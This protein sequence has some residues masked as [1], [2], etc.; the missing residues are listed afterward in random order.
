M[1]PV[2][3]FTA[4][5][6]GVIVWLFVASRLTARSWEHPGEVGD[7]GGVAIAPARIGLWAFMAVAT[8]LFSLLASAYLMR[9]HHGYWCHLELP[10]ILWVNTGLLIL[11]SIAF[12]RARWAAD[13][14]RKDQVRSGLAVGGVLT[15]A[16]LAGQFIAWR[17]LAPTMYF[18]Q[19]SPA[20]AS[21]H[22]LTAVHGLHV[23][24]GLWVWGRVMARLAGDAEVIDVRLSVQLCTVYWHFLLL[25]WLAL[26]A[27][28]N[29]T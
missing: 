21:F 8:S 10:R 5:I 17:E 23:L 12:Q 2:A 15:I 28:L 6:A 26:F 11:G 1:S 20:T 25:V 3:M 9:M 13:R 4:L 27:A 7:G 24:G 19:G 16:F 22:L 18:I 29:V 14:G